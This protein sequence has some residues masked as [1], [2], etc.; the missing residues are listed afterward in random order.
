MTQAGVLIIGGGIAGI[1]SSLDLADAGIPVVLVERDVSIGGKMAALDKNFPTLDCSI[2]I[3]A[4]KLSEVNQHPLIEILAA[5]EVV[6]LEG[7]AGDF[8]VGI[9]RNDP[10]V[11]D[12]CTRCDECVAVCPQLVAG[13]FDQHLRTRRAIYTPFAQATPGAYFVDLDNCLNEPPNYLPCQRC[14]EACMPQCIDFSLPRVQYLERQVGAVIVSTGFEMMDVSQIPEYGY[15]RHPDVL[16]AMEFERL[17][18]S[19]GP[20]GGHILRPSTGTE[21]QRVLFV[22]CV[23][24]RDRRF[25]SYCSR[26]CCM[27]SIKHA[28]QAR[29][30]GIPEATVLYMDIRAYGKGFD[31]FWDR[32]QETGVRFVRGRP[33]WIQPAGDEDG[34][35]QVRFSDTHTGLVQE[36]PFDL[37]VLA[38]AVT[39]AGRAEDLAA[40]LDIELDSD[41]FYRTRDEEGGMGES[42]RPGV[43]LAGCA[44]GPKDIPDSVAEAGAAA[45]L[46]AALAPV[47]GRID[48]G[49]AVEEI[50][51]AADDEARVGVVLCHCGNNIAGVVAMQELKAAAEAMPGVVHVETSLF[52]CAGNAQNV[53]GQLIREK[54][55]NR[56][57]VAACSPSTHQETFRGAC[58]RAGL[59]PYLMTMV[60]L[61]NHDSWVHKK[62]PA[63]A[64]H[65]AVD[66]VRMGVENARR[67]YPLKGIPQPVKRQAVVI[68]G[69]IG[70]M[71][72]A[73]GLARRGIPVHLVER[74]QQLG[75]RLN[76]LHLLAPG[77]L[78][79]RRLIERQVEDL[80]RAG[81]AIHLGTE[82]EEISGH[83]GRF[84]ARLT[85]GS[86]L[87]VG[88]VILAMGAEPYQPAEFAYGVDSRVVSSL[89]LEGMLDQVT[90]QRVTFVGCVGSR[91]GDIGCSRFC[92]ESM[93]AQALA[94]RDQGSQVSV[95]YRDIRTQGRHGEDLY[96][97]A[98]RAGVRFFRFDPE[99]HGQP[100]WDGELLRFHDDLLGAPV[101]LPSDLLV[102]VTGLR[103]VSENLAAQLKVPRSAD[104][105]LL[106][107]HPKL[108]PAEVG[109]P[110]IYLAG[111][112]QGPKGVRETVAQALAAASKAAILLAH[113]EMEKEPL[114]AQ[115]DADR[116]TGCTLCEPVCP[117]DAIEMIAV[118]G[119]K[120]G[121][122]VV[123]EAACEG[124]G[125]CA[126]ACNFDA[127][128][129]PYFT[130]DQ[131][132]AQIDAAL[133]ENPADKAIVFTC[134]WC[135]YAGAD[136]AGI[137]KVAYPS[138][139]RLIRTMCSGRVSEKFIRHAFDQ[140]AGGV[141]VTGC[142]PGDC[143]YL[144]ANQWTEK[145]FK[146]WSRKLGRQ[147]VGPERLRLEWVSAAEGRRFAGL[148]HE[149]NDAV[150]GERAAAG[151]EAND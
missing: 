133:S 109:K 25:F 123:T 122:A 75:G 121:L 35:L 17:V 76:H 63:G 100:W 104:G 50:L 145:R 37:V 91:Q 33:A 102:L 10:L 82:V 80:D 116:C 147:G 106:E 88:A 139:V 112:V 3:E 71:S 150:A 127:I 97:K 138:S 111:T 117:F 57:V 45:T 2:C 64:N 137:E 132:V 12:E 23:G 14:V 52:A 51:V 11:T 148:M 36:E 81:V 95:L 78:D 126:A 110:G 47:N 103:P 5:S 89:D 113:D 27:Y 46:A 128:T 1:Q 119:Q 134:N 26:F 49:P 43:F 136:Q 115:I 62:E 77:D 140:G 92:C 6:S 56:L 4:P 98:A 83:V 72:A 60:N 125:T 79:A 129:M 101:A 19:A 54:N 8:R 44:S 151:G 124:C 120:L 21:A 69:G 34:G 130:S 38:G 73:A 146:L 40:V 114:V 108:G 13:E 135:S 141:M 107:R 99:T 58:V 7:E 70:G 85:D 142:H 28:V 144:T 66:M 59:N 105:F 87:E 94:L 16:T 9:R 31:G 55:L 20:T 24:S 18:N 39:P 15:G 149:L 32:A 30:H 74:E 84:H 29:D 65:K 53:I 93:L 96:E 143:H 131:I 118:P 86:E 90:P 41:G 42:T 61:R 67:L 48:L 68:G 22:L